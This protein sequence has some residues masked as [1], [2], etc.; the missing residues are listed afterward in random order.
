MW[1]SADGLLLLFQCTISHL[2]SFS[3]D[4][5]WVRR[6][7][8]RTFYSYT[9][10]SC[11]DETRAAESGTK[12][13]RTSIPTPP[14]VHSVAAGFR[15]G[16]VRNRPGRSNT[17]SWRSWGQ[18]TAKAAKASHVGRWT[19]RIYPRTRSAIAWLL[20]ERNCFKHV[21]SKTLI[22]RTQTFHATKNGGLPD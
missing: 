3:P 8:G 15:S 2:A 21:K 22:T 11:G 18:M 10:Q 19:R 16:H 9:L 1:L 4:R 17:T 7:G 13:P 20:L 6:R 5:S 14:P 12:R